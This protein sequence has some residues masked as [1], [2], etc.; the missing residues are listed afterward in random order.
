MHVNRHNPKLSTADRVN[1]K[2][3][4]AAGERGCDLAREYDVNQSSISHIRHGSARPQRGD[5]A[6]VL[7]ATRDRIL[8]QWSP[9][10]PKQRCDRLSATLTVFACAE[11]HRV[12]EVG[13]MDRVYAACRGCAMGAA[14]LRSSIA[15][16]K[17]SQAS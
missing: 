11:R 6:S 8:P 17:T 15:E 13:D 1:I 12:A 3:R 5:R 2:L 14:N 16:Q 7:H 4:L 9:G 10:A